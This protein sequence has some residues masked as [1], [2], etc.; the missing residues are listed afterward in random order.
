MGGGG[1]G[2]GGGRGKNW[3]KK[4]EDEKR[5]GKLPTEKK[6]HRNGTVVVHRSNLLPNALPVAYCDSLALL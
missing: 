3:G 2:G 6:N 4:T 5:K 1:G